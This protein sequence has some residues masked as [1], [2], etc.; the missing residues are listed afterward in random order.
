MLGLLIVCLLPIADENR[1]IW[2]GTTKSPSTSKFIFSL[3]KYYYLSCKSIC[4][5][6]I[7]PFMFPFICLTKK[8]TDPKSSFKTRS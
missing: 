3:I 2:T 4:L 1:M 5:T 6:E 7:A 8:L